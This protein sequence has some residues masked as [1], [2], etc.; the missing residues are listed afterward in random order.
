[1]ILECGTALDDTAN[2]AN[3]IGAATIKAGQ[4]LRR[5]LAGNL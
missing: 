1:V 4:Y 3:A 5:I 2:E